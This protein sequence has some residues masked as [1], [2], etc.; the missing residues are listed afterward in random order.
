LLDISQPLKIGVF[1]KIK[2]QVGGDADKPVNGIVY[3]F[4]FVQFFIWC[5]KM[6]NKGNTPV[7]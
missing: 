1:D 6:L 7:L 2:Y 5:A 4:L 3:Y